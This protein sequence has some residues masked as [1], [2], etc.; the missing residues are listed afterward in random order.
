[1]IRGSI[2]IPIIIFV[3]F[4]LSLFGFSQAQY[5]NDESSLFSFSLGLTQSNL[6]KDSI[7]YKSGTSY[8]FGFIYSLKLS[9]RFNIAAELLYTG[10]SFKIDDP[11]IKYRYFFIDIPLYCQIKLSD[12]FRVN[13]G[14]QYSLAA[15]SKIVVI[16]GSKPNGIN[17]QESGNIKKRDYGFLLGV[18]LGLTKDIYL[19]ARY[20]L[21]G[22]T[23]FEKN[24]INFGVFQLSLNYFAYRS[25]RKFW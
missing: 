4:F 19:S 24:K 5:S 13:C 18:E 12:N 16:D 10:K 9:D 15:N 22:S 20:T 1:M 2:K 6:I 17:V 23:F 11:I 7:S 14:A 8:N 3:F 21:S 25:Y